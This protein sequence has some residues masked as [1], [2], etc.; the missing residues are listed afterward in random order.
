MKK[1]TL[2]ETDKQELRTA[3]DELISVIKTYFN[4]KIILA[5]TTSIANFTRYLNRYFASELQFTL[6]RAGF[7]PDVEEL[8]LAIQPEGEEEK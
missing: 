8:L 5:D 3:R 4:T 7:K 1:Q 2:S 6:E